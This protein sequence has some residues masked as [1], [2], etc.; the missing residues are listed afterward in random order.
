MLGSPWIVARRQSR[1]AR[2]NIYTE[3]AFCFLYPVQRCQGTHRLLFG[4][5]AGA[6]GCGGGN[7][8]RPSSPGWSPLAVIAPGPFNSAAHDSH[9]KR[10]GGYIPHVQMRNRPFCFLCIC[11]GVEQA[12]QINTH[13][14]PNRPTIA[15][16]PGL[17]SPC[18]TQSLAWMVGKRR[19]PGPLHGPPL[20]LS[21]IP[22]HPL[23]PASDGVSD[24]SRRPGSAAH[25]WH[26]ITKCHTFCCRLTHLSMLPSI[27]RLATRF[28]RPRI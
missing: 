12:A 20:P 8:P 14:A 28:G 18:L 6:K 26:P 21:A 3:W 7:H 22:T 25:I 17:A 16:L 27:R 13:S 19:N 10:H 24:T 5:S 23:H 2:A 4:H 11:R 15:R 1:Q 9:M